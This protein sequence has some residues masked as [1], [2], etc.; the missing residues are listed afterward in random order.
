MS[1]EFCPICGKPYSHR[2][3]RA[4]ASG[5]KWVYLHA[6]R[7]GSRRAFNQCAQPASFTADELECYSYLASHKNRW[8]HADD[9]PCLHAIDIWIDLG[10]VAQ[11]DGNLYLLYDHNRI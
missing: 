2:L 7:R 1:S 4:F 3:F 11:R 10:F 6:I 5:P 8:L 9:I